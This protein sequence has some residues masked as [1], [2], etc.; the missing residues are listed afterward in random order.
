MMETDKYAGHPSQLYGVT[1]FTFSS[2]KAKG[3]RA[4]EIRNGNGLEMTVLEDRG[5]DISRLTYKG[6][7]LSYLSKCGIVGPEY[8]DRTGLEFLQSFYVGFLTTCGLRHIG[9][10]CSVDGE[11]FGL[12]GRISHVPA[13]EVCARTEPAGDGAVIRVGG[14]LREARIFRENL[15]LHRTFEVPVGGKGFTIRNRIENRG[16]RPEAYMMMLHMNFGYPLL[17]G[18]ARLYIPTLQAEARDE[19]ARKG[20]D[21][22]RQM[23]EPHDRYP[24][25]VFFHTLKSD[26]GGR[27]CVA[28]VN[29][30]LQ[31]G[32]ALRYDTR[33]FPYTTQWKQ[34]ECGDYVLGIEPATCK[35]LGRAALAQRQELDY[36]PA[37]QYRDFDIEVEILDGKEEIETF[38][39]AFDSLYNR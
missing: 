2:G 30:D 15:L 14:V 5:L 22:F 35:M 6:T 36:L 28:L 19:D 18:K 7:N 11:E 26:A 24:E 32:V 33:A 10:P 29:E 31:T 1:P 8:Y 4:F 34:F 12:H 39:R 16:F 37:R 17:S 9:A 27:T 3:V 21:T 13:E 38:I 23:E 20:L 25:Q